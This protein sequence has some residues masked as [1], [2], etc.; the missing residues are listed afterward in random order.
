MKKLLTFCL[1]VVSMV[2]LS[3]CGNS[4]KT[5]EVHYADKDF[6]NSFVDGLQKRWDY[7]ESDQG[8]KD[9][10]DNMAEYVIK[11]NE[12]ELNALKKYKDEKFK[13]SNLQEK[14]LAYIN[15]IKNNIDVA[16]KYDDSK[17]IEKYNPVQEKRTIILTEIIK[18]YKPKFDDKHQKYADDLMK[19]GTQAKEENTQ[20]EAVNN[21]F[22]NVTFNKTDDGYGFFNCTAT[23]EN[24]TKYTIKNLSLTIKLVDDSNTVVSTTYASAENWTPGQKYNFE[25][26]TDKNF[27][28]TEVS[29]DYYEIAE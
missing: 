7:V 21:L 8:D 9:S 28:K 18:E 23:V 4:K 16:K 3:A 24:T 25:F 5:E 1:L 11:A 27:T 12:F 13:D 19:K 6:L 29:V 17:L 22:T 10:T 15:A 20:K 2:T 14:A 26:G